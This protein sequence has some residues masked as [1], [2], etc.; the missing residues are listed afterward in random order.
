MNTVTPSTLIFA[1]I[2]KAPNV[3]NSTATAPPA[4]IKSILANASSTNQQQSIQSSKQAQPMSQAAQNQIPIA[5]VN[6][7]NSIQQ[8]ANQTV[9]NDQRPNAYT[10]SFVGSNAAARTGTHLFE[11]I[12]ISI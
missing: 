5:I 3:V 6:A 4:Q 2:V 12:L 1:T 11:S 8:T 9:Q 7:P 10:P